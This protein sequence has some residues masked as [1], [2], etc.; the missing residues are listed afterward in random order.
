MAEKILLATKLMDVDGSINRDF[1]L[2]S[3]MGIS[4]QCCKRAYLRG[5]FLAGGSI[6]DP[7][8]SYHFEIVSSGMDKAVQIADTMKV[9]ELDARIVE[10]R[11][12]YVVYIKEGA[13]IVD[14]LNVMEARISLME[15]ENMRV[16]KEVRNS[17]NRK[18]NC[19]MANL[20]KTVNAAV[21]QIEDI[22]YIRDKVGL[23]YLDD[24][25]EEI[26]NLRLQYSEMSLKD[27]GEM[28]S[29]P[30]GKSGVNHRLR[31]ISQ[32]AEELRKKN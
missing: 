15:L 18:F 5:S 20:S 32:I 12:S 24:N 2:T 21:K 1:A 30:V 7:E 13:Q 19:E 25:L 14:M 23:D 10:R 28:L 17:V 8:K 6:S 22:E 29:V 3:T 16:V 26:A 11:N 9:Y 27:L 31:K 4:S